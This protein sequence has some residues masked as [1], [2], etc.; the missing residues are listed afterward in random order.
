MN[1]IS[2]RMRTLCF[3]STCLE[4]E[5]CFGKSSVEECEALLKSVV[6]KRAKAAT[7]TWIKALKL[8]KAELDLGTCSKEQLATTLEGLYVDV[9]KQDGTKYKR[10]SYLSASN[11]QQS[12]LVYKGST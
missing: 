3:F 8:Y 11:H 12:K 9:R 7:E 5:V 2:K 10:A 1:I 6:P 4:M